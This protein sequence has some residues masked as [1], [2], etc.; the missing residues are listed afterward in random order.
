MPLRNLQKYRARPSD[1]N[2]AQG[3]H[4]LKGSPS[5]LCA[6]DTTRGSRADC[7]SMP[8]YGKRLDAND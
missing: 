3:L 6:K 5:D 4:S 2:P 8:S 7:R 1:S